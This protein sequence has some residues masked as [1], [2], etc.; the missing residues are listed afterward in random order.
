[1]HGI[2]TM[3]VREILRDVVEA[4]VSAGKTVWDWKWRILIAFAAVALIAVIGAFLIGVREFL[5]EASPV[6]G[7]HAV[8]VA[9]ILDVYLTVMSF[10]NAAFSA[11]YDMVIEV[12]GKFFPSVASMPLRKIT[13][14]FY[15][16]SAATIKADL[17]NFVV[18]CHDINTVPK[19][20]RAVTHAYVGPTLCPWLRYLWPVPW[21]RTTL[22]QTIGWMSPDPTPLGYPG[23][24]NCKPTA[25]M[26]RS[27][28][29]M[30]GYAGMGYVIVEVVVP[31]IFGLFLLA[32][33]VAWWFQYR[34][35]QRKR[36]TAN[37][38]DTVDTLKRE[39]SE[40]EKRE[41]KNV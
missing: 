34:A 38:V 10:M 6:I 13:V 2:G 30:C 14:Q 9:V 5:L 12:L 18:Q 28:A 33:L 7:D 23:E 16:I 41:K 1:M 35:L 19:V 11:I 3:V 25:G 27:N 24:N 31:I 15:N 32:F 21:L 26:S 8:L 4:L 36:K 37:L 22:D 40:L 39:V 29:A 20:F 17:N